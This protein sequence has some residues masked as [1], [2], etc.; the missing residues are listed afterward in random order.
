MINLVK[1]D[2]LVVMPIFEN[3]SYYF[4]MITLMKNVDNFQI[5]KVKP[6]GANLLLLPI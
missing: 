4:L 1:T 6:E 5:G 2:I 3:M